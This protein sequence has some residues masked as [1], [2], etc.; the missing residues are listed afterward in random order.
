MTLGSVTDESEGIVLEVSLEL[1]ERPVG[2]PE[3]VREVVEK[4]RGKEEVSEKE[5]KMER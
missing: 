1:R 2:T 5:S 3:V 4:L